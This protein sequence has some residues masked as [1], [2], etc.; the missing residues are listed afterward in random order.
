M[1]VSSEGDNSEL[2]GVVGAG[3]LTAARSGLSTELD[4]AAER[5]VVENLLQGLLDRLS[6]QDR[7]LLELK[8]EGGSI[9]AAAR[10]LGKSSEWGSQA[11]KKVVACLR[12]GVRQHAEAD[13][14]VAAVLSSY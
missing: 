9:A 1:D 14:E 5:V 4:T 6:P 10:E 8:L 7:H 2:S 3:G 13:A 12:E 11:V